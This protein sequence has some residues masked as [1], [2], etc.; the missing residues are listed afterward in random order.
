MERM[1]DFAKRAVDDKKAWPLAPG[2]TT[3]SQPTDSGRGAKPQ[4][5]EHK[6]ACMASLAHHMERMGALAKQAVDDK[7]ASPLGHGES[8]VHDI[9][10]T[11]CQ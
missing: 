11:N 10:R 6:S 2:F 8:R 4:A 7:K 1:E 3:S 9:K 5:N